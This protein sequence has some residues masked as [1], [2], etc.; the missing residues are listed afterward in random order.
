MAR[1]IVTTATDAVGRS[2]N[3]KRP[4]P[5]VWTLASA[6][7]LP[8]Q[9]AAAAD[10]TF[11]P[12]IDL[13]ETYSD[14]VALAQAGAEKTDFV[15][16]VTPR[17]SL[18]GIGPYL[19]LNATYALHNYL[20]AHES[21]NAR[22]R[23]QLNASGNAEL[24][25]EWLFVD[26]TASRSPQS[27]SPFGPQLT[28]PSSLTT[29][30]TEVTTY[31]VSPY[32]RHRFENLASSELRYTRDSVSTN[33][34]GL[35]DS[36][37][38]RFLGRLTS[39][40]ALREIKWGVQY[41]QQKIEYDNAATV[42]TSVFSGNLRYLISP[43]Y[44]LTA[45]AGYEKHD[46]ASSIG[47][48]KGRFWSVGAAWTPSQRTMIEGSAG[49]RFYGD[50]FA[51]SGTHYTRH[52]IWSLNYQEDITTA[53]SQFMLPVTT[54]TSS[55]LDQLWSASIPDPVTREQFIA[56]FIRD[57]GLPSALTLP[58]NSFTDRVFLQK[59][60][61]GSV[62]ING[63]RNTV[64]FG[65]FNTL[66]K[67]QTSPSTDDTAPGA[68]GAATD[69][70]TRQVGAHA[71]WQWRITPRTNAH[72]DAVYSRV[73]SSI[74]DRRDH[75]LTTRVAMTKQFQPK[76]HGGLEWRR[77]RQRSNV[78]GGDVTENALTAYVQMGF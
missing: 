65:V 50:T 19:K 2:T 29:N 33:T 56:S 76:V 12:S 70:D 36:H 39:G 71:L 30:R 67:P 60:L 69:V 55:F 54:D 47:N 18:T 14:N 22:T 5:V 72:V 7:L 26:G 15:T 51:L 16:E 24:I 6:A 28:D 34:G 20:Y 13:R 44:S 48:S 3:T 4:L 17:I 59:S 73:S 68:T 52:T 35:L 9:Y 53:R 77:Q 62:A 8:L 64:L 46:Y 32:L 25:D 42:D 38:D 49:K 1:I 37:S 66:R 40:P 58:V 61:Q 27:I 41:D 31:S 63:A 10:W 43:L 78:N 23:Q 45:A 57:T 11:T 21:G 74:T 75:N